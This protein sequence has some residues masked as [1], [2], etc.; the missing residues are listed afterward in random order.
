MKSYLRNV[1]FEGGVK[2]CQ[3]SIKE[4]SV[5][6]QIPH[7]PPRRFTGFRQLRRFVNSIDSTLFNR[8][9]SFIQTNIIKHIVKCSSVPSVNLG[10]EVTYQWKRISFSPRTD[11]YIQNVPC[12]RRT[13][14]FESISTSLLPVCRSSRRKTAETYSTQPHQILREDP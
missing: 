14:R 7:S 11:V 6:Q 8:P 13:G 9:L 5:F 4:V 12:C 3:D 2:P 1:D 10:F